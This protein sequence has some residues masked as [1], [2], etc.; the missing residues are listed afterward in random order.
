MTKL[1]LNQEKF[2]DKE[3]DIKHKDV[4][5]FVSEGEWT[6]SRRF[7]RED[8]TPVNQYNINIKLSNGEVRSIT[9]AYSNLKLL[10]EAWGD[11]TLTWIGKQVRAW[12]TKSDRAKTGYVFFYTPTSWDRDDTGEW[13]I[14]EGEKKI[15]SEEESL[16]EMAPD[17]D[18]INID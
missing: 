18:E 4:V 3:K 16:E 12:K 5:E 11:E 14:P 17:E 2:L 6:E 10:G 9:L 1:N 13:V 8:G 15:K 7:K